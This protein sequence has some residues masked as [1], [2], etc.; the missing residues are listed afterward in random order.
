MGK[1]TAILL[2]MISVSVARAD[3]CVLPSTI[4][5]ASDNGDI[6]V[7]IEYGWP[8]DL[9]PPPRQMHMPRTCVATI[10][11]WNE[12]DRNY[13]FL[14]SVVLR[15]RIGPSEAVISN[16]GR[17]LVTFDEFCESGMSEN[18][19]VIYDLEKD[20]TVAC[21]IEDFLPKAYR[22]SLHRSISHLNWRDQ[23]PYLNDED[24][25]V[26]IYPSSNTKA[27]FSI[28]VDLTSYSITLDPPQPQ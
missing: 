16:E 26:R 19:V 18:D 9:G 6:A 7:R 13:R 20:I 4:G 5:F 21:S 11:K 1:L 25:Y 28:L 2:L 12:K 22:D 10:A 14:R 17:F 3:S 24:R 15:N 27:G 23:H 8:E